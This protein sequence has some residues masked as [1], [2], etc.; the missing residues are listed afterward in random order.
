M[1]A[2]LTR[3]HSETLYGTAMDTGAVLGIA[4]LVVSVIALLM[5]STLSARQ[6]G[7]MRDANHIPAV[8]NLLS[9][10][11]QVGLHDDYYFVTERLRSEHDPR[12]GISELPPEVRKSVVNVAFYFQTFAFLVG[13]GILD[14]RKLF[15]TALRVRIVNVWR[16]IEPYVL[17]ERSKHGLDLLAMLEALSGLTESKPMIQS[18][19]AR[20]RREHELLRIVS[21]T[22][23]DSQ[24]KSSQSLA[25]KTGGLS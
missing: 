18:L 6:V 25:E 23:L 22:S 24:I 13:F 9:E 20:F 5:S 4:A 10:F 15:M 2:K 3:L 8:I 16:S 19:A 12:L 7:L 1:G 21:R 11:R 14:E 17:T